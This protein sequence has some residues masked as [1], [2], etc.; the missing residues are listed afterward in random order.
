MAVLMRRDDGDLTELLNAIADDPASAPQDLFRAVYYELR[1][2]AEGAMARQPRH[3]TMNATGLVHQVYLKLFRDESVRWKSRRHFFAVA[4]VAMKSVLVDH[5]R[6]KRCQKRVEPGERNLLDE[7]MEACQ[8]RIGGRAVDPL[9]VA[10][11]LDEMRAVNARACEVVHCRFYLGLPMKEIAAFMGE[12]TR[13]IERDWMWA[14]AWL[15]EK[16]G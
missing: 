16:L 13:T 6:A 2:H 10:D 4:S 9:D 12:P 14:R 1:R 8:T 15:A 7:L 5:S 11:A 3:H